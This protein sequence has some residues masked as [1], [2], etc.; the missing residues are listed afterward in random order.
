MKTMRE[1]GMK[2]CGMV[3]TSCAAVLSLAMAVFAAAASA[4]TI[5]I[6]E[7]QR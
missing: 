1:K 7:W 3:E 4:K 6:A 5:A 2:K